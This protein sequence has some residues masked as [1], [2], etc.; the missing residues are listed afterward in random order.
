MAKRTQQA[1]SEPS[2]QIIYVGA[3]IERIGLQQ[4]AVYRGGIPE[5][6]QDAVKACPDLAELFVPITQLNHARRDIQ[7]KGSALRSY[8]LNARS[9]FINP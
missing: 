6:A 9:F 8:Y 5:F 1:G 7:R 3:S 4:Y 2:D